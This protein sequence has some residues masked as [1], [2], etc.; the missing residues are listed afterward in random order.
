VLREQ[1]VRPLSRLLLGRHR[2]CC[3]RRRRKCLH[4][5]QQRPRQTCLRHLST[6]PDSNHVL[7]RFQRAARTP[8]HALRALLASARREWEHRLPPPCAGGRRTR[9]LPCSTW[10]RR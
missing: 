2:C 5:S 4:A 3:A 7:R 1:Q 9:R 6:K 8:P 10:R